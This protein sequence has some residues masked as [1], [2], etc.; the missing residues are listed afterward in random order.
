MI[1]SNA[2]IVEFLKT[3][4]P[5]ATKVGTD[6][7]AG[8]LKDGFEL[9]PAI[10]VST[11]GGKAEVYIP[12]IKPSIQVKCYGTTQ[13]E[14]REVYGLIFDALHGIDSITLG[15]GRHIASALEEV[16]GQDLI[17]PDTN[18]PFVLAFFEV[19]LRA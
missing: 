12:H 11:R 13:M 8:R 2:A 14:A 19:R 15:S 6:I 17:D 18:W 4:G 16:Q 5:L 10:V 1:D 7:Y 9:G 3:D